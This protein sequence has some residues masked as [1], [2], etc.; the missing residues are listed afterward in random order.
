VLQRISDLPIRQA[1]S[2]VIE[3]RLPRGV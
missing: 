3:T 1:L 2:N